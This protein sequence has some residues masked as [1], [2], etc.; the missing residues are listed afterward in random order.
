[1]IGSFPKLFEY[2]SQQTQGSRYSFVLLT[3]KH[4]ELYPSPTPLLNSL[5]RKVLE[6]K[7]RVHVIIRQREMCRVQFEYFE[8]SGGSN[9]PTIFNV[10]CN[11]TSTPIT[12]LFHEYP[13]TAK[14]ISMPCKLPSAQPTP[15]TTTLPCPC[16]TFSVKKSRNICLM[17]GA[18][19]ELSILSHSATG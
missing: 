8:T 12:H 7:H 2:F 5:K 10:Q 9:E 4:D 3:V 1:M 14:A 13:L 18:D 11:F 19:R 15:T 17:A 6:N 16:P